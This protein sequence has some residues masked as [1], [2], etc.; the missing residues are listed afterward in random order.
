MGEPT[1]QTTD[2]LDLERLFTMSLDMICLAGTDGYFKR[3][4][5]AFVETLGYTVEELLRRPFLDLVHPDD[6]VATL[7]EV[8][9]LGRGEPTIH[10]ENRYARADGTW[11]WMAWRA[12]ADAESGLIYAVARDVTAQKVAAQALA[13]REAQLEAIVESVS[14]GLLAF[15]ADGRV[16]RTNRAASEVFGMPT[17]DLLGARLSE[18]VPE[19]Y[20]TEVGEG[21]VAGQAPS[22]IREI[23]GRRADGETFPMEVTFSRVEL[24][25]RAGS[26]AVVRDITARRTD[27]IERRELLSSIAHETG[28]A[29]SVSGLLHDLGNA[30]TGVISQSVEAADRLQGSK[31]VSRLQKTSGLLE[32]EQDRLAGALGEERAAALRELI[33]G[34]AQDLEG[35]QRMV[36]AALSKALAF[37][38]HA[39]EV[40]QAHRGYAGSGPRREATPM[41][42]I[43]ADAQLMM[44]DAFARRHGRLD[45]RVDP[46]DLS[47]EVERSKLMQVLL[48][49]LKNA[50]EAFDQT[51]G[52]AVPMVRLESGRADGATWIEVRDNG[53]G[54]E[55]DKLGRV[56]EDGFTTKRRGSG[57]GLGA[58]RRVIESIGG[59]LEMRSEGPGQG[60]TARIEWKGGAR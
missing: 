7:A 50:A 33:V 27:A 1:S 23:V 48:N 59:T 53:P 26:L 17:A 40:L 21:F 44:S 36:G 35:E 49:L 20:A 54:I 16:E 9:R 56:F 30:L 42:R 52:E 45:L 41:R 58:A 24:P 51:D 3:V 11:C 37:T 25:D 13:A 6:I 32:R 55:G 34:M 60:A 2:V 5:P 43:L 47:I 18:L 31:V 14:D 19:P 12:S 4:N 15:D 38:Q 29:E 57:V 8:E 39:Q 46:P 22:T 28:R 10:F